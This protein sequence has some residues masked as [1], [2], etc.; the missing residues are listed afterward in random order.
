MDAEMQLIKPKNKDQQLD[1]ETWTPSTQ[2][3]E[4][5]DDPINPV[6]YST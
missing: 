3:G 1:W 2:V 5:M 6:L 4:V